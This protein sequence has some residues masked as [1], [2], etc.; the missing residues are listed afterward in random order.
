MTET[1]EKFIDPWSR[2]PIVSE[3]VTNKKCRHTYEKSTVMKFLETYS[4]KK[5]NLK[6]PVMGCGN[7]NIIKSDLYTDPE[8]KRKVAQQSRER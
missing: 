1:T 6:C 5:K 3:P 7:D 2:K 4:K 8:I